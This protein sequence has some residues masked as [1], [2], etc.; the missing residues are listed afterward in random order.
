[1][2]NGVSI[3][4]DR[5][6]LLTQSKNLLNKEGRGSHKN[7]LHQGRYINNRNR[8]GKYD[9]NECIISTRG[10][11]E[12]TSIEQSGKEKNLHKLTNGLLGCQ[13]IAK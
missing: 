3:V 12:L 4:L 5:E 11:L 7:G 1:M 13:V 8:D 6:H 9:L 2:V 10:F